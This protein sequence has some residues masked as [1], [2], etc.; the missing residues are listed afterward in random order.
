MASCRIDVLGPPRV[1][2]DGE[3]RDGLRKKTIA[4]LSYLAVEDRPIARDTLA[5]LLWPDHGQSDARRN[6]R[7]C[8]SE[9]RSRVG[10]EAVA[11]TADCV[12]LSREAVA[13]DILELRLVRPESIGVRER[14]LLCE[15]EFLEGFTLRDC[16]E[17]DV[18]QFQVGEAI[19]A[20]RGRI[21][22]AAAA[23]SLT[24]GRADE[25]ADLCGE[26][27]RRDPLDEAAHRLAMRSFAA[28]GRWA[29]A[30]RQFGTCARVLE[31][32]L[33]AEPDQET[34]TLFERV[35]N[36]DPALLGVRSAGS[37]VRIPEETEP[38]YGRR[39]AAADVRRALHESR[40]VTLTGPGG[41]GKT[42]LA[43][44]V[45]HAA[46]EDYDD[47]IIYADL[48]T[49]DSEAE[50]LRA[51]GIAAGTRD[52]SAAGEVETIADQLDGR[53]LMVVLDNF[54]HVIG[55]APQIAELLS[56][57]RGPR[58]LVTSREP[59]RLTGELIVPVPPL[60]LPKSTTEEDV[61]AA[62]AVQLLVGKAS[63]AGIPLGTGAAAIDAL[64]RI[65]D[66]LDGLPLALELLVPWLR[67]HDAPAVADRLSASGAEALGATAPH[68]PARHR[69]LQAAFD[70]SYDLLNPDERRLF[71]GLSLFANGFDYRAVES[72]C[73][74]LCRT[75]PLKTCLSSLV[76]KH[77]LRRLDAGPVLGML[78][79]IRQYAESKTAE[80]AG[81][82]EISRRHA[83]YYTRAACELAAKLCGPD[84]GAAL[85][86]LSEMR[87][88]IARAL[89]W[90]RDR[91][92]HDEPDAAEKG[93]RTAVELVWFWHRSST[94]SEGRRWV[95]TFWDASD[96]PRL[97]GRAWFV[98]GLLTFF[99]GEWRKATRL[100]EEA[101]QR[102]AHDMETR[103]YALSF[104]GVACRWLGARDVGWRHG[105]EAIACARQ[106]RSE[107]ALV[108]VLTVGTCTC[109]GSFPG[110]PPYDALREAL[111]RAVA[112]GD[113]W[114][115][116]H[117]YNGYGDLYTALGDCGTAQKAYEESLRRFS[118]IGD[119]YMIAWNYEGLA[120]LAMRAEDAGAAVDWGR[121]ALAAFDSIGDELDSA[122]M[123][124]RVAGLSIGDERSGRLAGASL[125]ILSRLRQ[126]ELSGAPQVEEAL[127]TIEVL[128]RTHPVAFDAGRLLTRAEAVA[129]T[130]ELG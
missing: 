107:P 103:A 87:P 33:D 128:Q 116:A 26:L 125:S 32:E 109:G 47:G 110:E 104:L 97:V 79:P 48:T 59:L 15:G 77:L 80:V 1:L 126:E 117:V 78:E 22:R 57:V 99:L 6:L 21:V 52:R 81:L 20:L 93:L 16:R 91:P 46:R 92:R 88:N 54:E 73:D 28:T 9:A 42:R 105:W 8:L 49:V 127:S 75:S 31:E 96:E 5:T 101:A 94:F 45:C 121:K 83:A 44:H 17:F 102:S 13:S 4:L 65:A 12:E 67:I 11:S 29:L 18:W 51:L 62:P 114:S 37:P 41:C 10:P 119:R 43:I 72:I 89:S 118:E 90:L 70:W 122:L 3:L 38:I 112:L 86:T 56:R 58:F 50:V 98:R 19:R 25:A 111:D 85:S 23:A 39:G 7:T 34:V 106:S 66:R 61:L 100:L 84:Q 30:E 129:L 68:G 40:L 113:V 36:H 55:A 64:R 53:L 24:N 14:T 115:A 82:G 63:R 108:K 123:L 120:T 124:A 2:V 76:E 35:R 130:R 71:V 60:A 27:V 95:E 74:P 69:S